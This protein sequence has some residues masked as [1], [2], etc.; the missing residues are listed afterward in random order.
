[1]TADPLLP[2]EQIAIGGRF[3]VR[4]YREN[5]LVRDNGLLVSLE[6]HIP[7]I[8]NQRWAEVVQVIPFVDFGRGWNRKVPTPEPTMLVSIGLGLR[9]VAQWQAFVPLR[10]QFEVFWGYKLQDI[11]TE[12]DDL[13]DKGL[14]LQFVVAA[15]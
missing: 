11:E 2:L 10:T 15:F 9:W 4:G 12:G 3:S 1:L 13:Q 6:S 14:H 7:L 8:R 5:E